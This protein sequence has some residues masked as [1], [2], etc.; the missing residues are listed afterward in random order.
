MK[1][2][3][4]IYRNRKLIIKIIL[5]VIVAIVSF[6]F[7]YT[8]FKKE[9]ELIENEEQ[10]EIKEEIIIKNMTKEEKMD[11]ILFLIENDIFSSA[12]YNKP[13][14]LKTSYI[15]HKLINWDTNPIINDVEKQFI[16]ENYMLEDWQVERAIPYQLIEDYYFNLTGEYPPEKDSSDC[17]IYIE[18]YDYYIHTEGH[19]WWGGF[20]ESLTFGSENGELIF[21]YPVE[22]IQNEDTYTLKVKQYQLMIEDEFTDNNLIKATLLDFIDEKINSETANMTEYANAEYT[23]KYENDKWMFQAYQLDIINPQIS[24]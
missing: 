4:F 17:M 2:Q 16:I 13:S 19:G 7:I 10:E 1:T 18:E 11:F 3:E 8:N 23:L 5:F 24:E 6:I 21:F 15:A 20:I 9:K 14:D 12:P 22:L